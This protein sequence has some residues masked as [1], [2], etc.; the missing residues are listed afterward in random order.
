MAPPRLDRTAIEETL[1]ILAE[2]GGSRTIAAARLNIC[3]NA[4]RN[5]LLHAQRLGLSIT[6]APRTGMARD[7]VKEA[8][9]APPGA[10][11]SVSEPDLH[12]SD[13]RKIR[14]L[15]AERDALRRDLKR[16][17]E[18]ADTA[19]NIRSGLLGLRDE[20]PAPANWPEAPAVHDV[21]ELLPLLFTSDFQCGEFVDPRELDGMNG[22]N[23]DVFSERYVRLIDRTIDLAMHHVGRATFAGSFYL[24]GGD[25]ISGGIHEELAE[26]DDLSSIPAVRWL[27]AHE[28]EGIRRQRAQFGRCRVVSIPGN[29]GRTTRKPRSKGYVAHNFETLLAWWLESSFADDPNVEFVTPASGDAF[30]DAL[31]WKVLMTHGDRTGSRGGMGFIGPAATIARGHKKV[32]DDWARSGISLDYILTGHLHSSMK[33]SLGYANGS[34]P[35][36]T[37]FARDN[38]LAAEIP[39]QWLLFF[40]RERGVAAQYEVQVG[41]RP[42]RHTPN[43][44]L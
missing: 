41:P 34:L 11:C 43:I 9:G 42:I 2:C 16:A 13:A 10:P 5:R 38:R 15:E 23:M 4:L 26:T 28:R 33:L 1:R 44:G 19:E 6:P 36:I 12:S 20:P 21:P 31:G 25:A 40:N 39:V 27:F 29:H 17:L 3:G 32:Y 37:Q 18:R 30:I 8:V 7:L 24:R 35:G 22:Y 14:R